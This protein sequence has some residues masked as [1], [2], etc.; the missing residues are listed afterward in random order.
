MLRVDKLVIMNACSVVGRL[1]PA[2]FI[3]SIGVVNMVIGSAFGCS[4]M[5]FAFLGLNSAAS[6][7]LIAVFYGLMAG[8]C[9]SFPSLAC[10]RLLTSPSSV[11]SLQAPVVAVI[12]PDISELG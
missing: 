6:V 1:L 11:I 12:T 5:I 9:K 7:V 4:I 2:L 10:P 3:Q 8:V